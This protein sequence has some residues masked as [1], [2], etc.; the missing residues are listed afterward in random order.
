MSHDVIIQWTLAVLVHWTIT[1]FP[2]MESYLLSPIC[3]IVKPLFLYK[4]FLWRKIK[5]IV[6]LCPVMLYS[7]T[8][9]TIL[10]FVS[11]IITAWAILKVSYGSAHVKM[12]SSVYYLL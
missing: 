7:T 6:E 3:P 4:S 12:I 5:N 11:R 2:Y 9:G 1:H 10:V 8:P